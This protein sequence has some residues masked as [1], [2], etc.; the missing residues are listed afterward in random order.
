MRGL[1]V[2]DGRKVDELLVVL[3]ARLR[4]DGSEEWVSGVDG[5][6]C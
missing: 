3:T 2:I 4:D 6:T 5:A 1:L